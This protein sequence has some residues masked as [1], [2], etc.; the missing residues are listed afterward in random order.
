MGLC[1]IIQRTECSREGD[2]KGMGE[3]GVR[4]LWTKMS[5]LEYVTTWGR[6]G[7]VR[8]TFH[9]KDNGDFM[10]CSVHDPHYSM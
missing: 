1:L 2:R 9:A 7:V 10:F 5:Q 6:T 8:V 4:R 3:G